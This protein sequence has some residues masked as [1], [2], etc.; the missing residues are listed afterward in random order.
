ML[1]PE[2]KD[3]IETLFFGKVLAQDEEL[4]EFKAKFKYL[5]PLGQ[6][7]FAIV[8]AAKWLDKDEERTVAVKCF[9]KEDFER[10]SIEQFRKEAKMTQNIHHD[11]LL[12]NLAVKVPP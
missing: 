11:H 5:G 6:G 1:T 8:V 7:A 10:N 9:C 4:E 12:N 3:K 2:Q